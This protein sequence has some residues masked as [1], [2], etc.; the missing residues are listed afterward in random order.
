MCVFL[1]KSKI[2]CGYF[3]AG[4][5]S[6]LKQATSIAQHMVKDWGMSE[7]V[8]LRTIEGPKGLMA[9]ETLGTSAIELVGTPKSSITAIINRKLS[10]QYKLG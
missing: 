10:F 1:Q 5:S 3:I 7:K 4:A 9:S 8:G 2:K 6:D